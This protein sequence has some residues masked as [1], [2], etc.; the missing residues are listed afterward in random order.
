MP[1]RLDSLQFG[2][3]Q[4]IGS[5]GCSFSLA[6]LNMLEKLNDLNHDKIEIISIWGDNSKDVWLN[7]HPDLKEKITWTNLWD[8]LEFAYSYLNTN[9][10]PTFY[11]INEEGEVVD[12]I[13]GYNKKTE[14]RLRK[15]IQYF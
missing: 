14:K 12:I 9:M 1:N 11:I 8:E 15:F 2:M 6:S 4:A 10:W 13:R 5:S 3:H 7:A